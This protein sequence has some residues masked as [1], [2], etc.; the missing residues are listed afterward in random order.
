MAFTCPSCQNPAAEGRDVC[1]ACG[2]SL[3]ELDR[4]LGIPPQLSAPVA[5]RFMH[6]P[7]SDVRRIAALTAAIEKR[8]PQVHLAAVIDHVP[9]DVAMAVYTFW[10]FNRSGI[11]S[12]VER[13]ADNHLVLLLIDATEGGASKGAACMIGYGLEPF[14][15]WHQLEACLGV[16]KAELAGRRL[17]SAIIAFFNDVQAVL[18]E[19]CVRANR[20]ELLK[21]TQAA[22]PSELV[23]NDTTSGD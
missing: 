21:D 2:F 23:P 5:D 16:M 20:D 15:K 14:V 7:A 6:L 18:Q 13:G 4:R 12:P 9:E 1:I 8:F 19:S 11:S 22:A 17:A 3:A 10:V